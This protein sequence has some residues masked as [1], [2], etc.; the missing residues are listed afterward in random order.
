MT[1]RRIMSGFFAKEKRQ[2]DDSEVMDLMTVAK[3]RLFTNLGLNDL[4]GIIIVI[5]NFTRLQNSIVKKANEKII[6]SFILHTIR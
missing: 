2:G 1:L 6:I 3:R 5:H 4:H